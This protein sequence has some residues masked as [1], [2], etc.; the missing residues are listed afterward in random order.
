MVK[1]SDETAVRSDPVRAGYR[2][3]LPRGILSDQPQI[4]GYVAMVVADLPR[5]ADGFSPDQHET[6]PGTAEVEWV[7]YQLPARGALD[8]AEPWVRGTPV[9]GWAA[10]AILTVTAEIRARR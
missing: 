2:I 3:L 4:D 6:V 8:R 7:A 10:G 5:L 9:P 1:M